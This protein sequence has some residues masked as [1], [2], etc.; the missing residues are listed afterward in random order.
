VRHRANA[1]L[2]VAFTV[3]PAD[4]EQGQGVLTP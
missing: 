3:E 2:E 1:H 4:I